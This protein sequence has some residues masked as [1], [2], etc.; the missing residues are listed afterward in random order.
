MSSDD[1][2]RSTAFLVFANDV[3]PARREAYECWHGGHHV[4]QRLTVP[5]I[6]RATRY[7]AAAGGSPE[8]LTVYDL[9]DIAVL[10][11]P[12]YR[13]L[14]E[15]PDAVTLAMRPHLRQPLRLACHALAAA[16]CAHGPILVMLRMPGANATRAAQWLSAGAVPPAI[17]L[18][19]TAPDAG[20]HP[21]MRQE[22]MPDE[23]VALVFA[24]TPEQARAALEAAGRAGLKALQAPGSGLIY[25]R[26]E[27]FA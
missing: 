7:R 23:A 19:R 27:S 22:G 26:I 8:Y 15:Q 4:P 24:A 12:A 9:A 21:I 25:E 11:Q 1:R 18:G 17:R 14:A 5:G 2:P 16:D 20:G 3:D 10:D 6:L 13:R